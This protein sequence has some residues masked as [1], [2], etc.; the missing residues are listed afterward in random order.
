M[1][2]THG[3]TMVTDEELLAAFDDIPGPY[4]TASELAET[5]PISRTAINKRLNR[6]HEEGRVG[7]KQ[8]IQQFV[9]W[10][11]LEDKMPDDN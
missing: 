4:V 1:P 8:P 3:N 5:L 10:W 11:K 7:R 6:L 2:G 9:G